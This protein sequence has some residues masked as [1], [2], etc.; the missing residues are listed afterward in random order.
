MNL[1]DYVLDLLLFVPRYLKPNSSF[2]TSENSGTL[3]SQ[4]KVYQ[5]DH[6][7]YVLPI[8][9]KILPLLVHITQ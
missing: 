5:V 3:G 2:P 7:N 4:K 6:Y 9:K 8:Q 1:S